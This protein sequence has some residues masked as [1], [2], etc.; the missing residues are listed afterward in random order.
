[1]D[2]VVLVPDGLRLD[3]EPLL[4]EVPEQLGV[5]LLSP[6]AARLLPQVLCEAGAVEVVVAVRHQCGQ[7]A[8]E[9]LRVEVVLREDESEVLSGHG[10]RARSLQQGRGPERMALLDRTERVERF[11]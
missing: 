7:V 2:R 11:L 1:M 5:S 3:P 10:S 6:I 8:C 4:E 9:I